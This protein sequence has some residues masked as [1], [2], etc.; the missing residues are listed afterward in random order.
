MKLFLQVGSVMKLDE[1]KEKEWREISEVV[2]EVVA[3]PATIGKGGPLSYSKRE[4][5]F[6][7]MPVH[8]QHV[9][10]ARSKCSP[11]KIFDICTSQC[12]GI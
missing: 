5:L 11:K 12:S 3:G 2:R 8:S 10:N 1:E 9:G 4:S 6:G 7:Q